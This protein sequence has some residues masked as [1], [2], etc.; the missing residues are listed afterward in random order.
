MGVSVFVLPQSKESK[1]ENRSLS[2]NNDIKLSNFSATSESILSDQFYFRDYIIDNN[3]R[4]NA[5]LSSKFG[6]DVISDV[7]V[8]PLSDD[9]VKLNDGYYANSALD[10][11]ENSMDSASMSGYRISQ[12]DLQYPDIKT[13]VYKCSRIEE[14]IN[15]EYPYQDKLW[16]AIQLQLNP[17]ITSSKLEIDSIYDYQKYY[18][19]TDHHW[20]ATGAYQGYK[21]IIGMINKDYDIG[22]PKEIKNE[23]VYPYQFKGNIINNMYINETDNIN[24]YALEDIREF[25]FYIDDELKDYYEIKELY[26]EQG[27]QTSYT[28]YEYYYGISA[29]TKVFDFYNEDKPNLLIIG[30]SYCNVNGLWI[31]SHFNKTVFI[32]VWVI[33]YDYSPKYYID[34]YDIDIA[35]V[36]M[37][38]ERLYDGLDIPLN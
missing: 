34:K 33:P 8:A 29:A 28:D 17:N 32:D 25:D 37:G 6:K 1:K 13:Y 30:S 7:S 24:D 11:S 12:F 9:I 26:K 31:A 21:D 23:I 16:E 27:N 22:E 4:F 10:Y 15:S 14:L 35:L 5:F 2:T 3:F 38:Q 36:Y 19:K 18:F 20:N